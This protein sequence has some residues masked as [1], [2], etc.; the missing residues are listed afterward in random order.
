[1][2]T[3][4]KSRIVSLCYAAATVAAADRCETAWANFGGARR[5]TSWSAQFS[6][7]YA[8]V[9]GAAASKERPPY[10]GRDPAATHVRNCH[11]RVSVP[12]RRLHCT[13]AI[14]IGD[15]LSLITPAWTT[16]R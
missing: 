9:V 12:E 2:R 8:D 1:V 7:A 5:T 13:E 15:S 6:K 3:I 10:S 16:L 11:G 4:L 14:A